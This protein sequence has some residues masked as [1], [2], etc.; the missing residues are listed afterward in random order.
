MKSCL[1]SPPS[2]GARAS[3]SLT[4]APS[5]TG[6]VIIFYFFFLFYAFLTSFFHSLFSRV[7]QDLP[8]CWSRLPPH[9]LCGILREVGPHPH[10]QHYCVRNLLSLLLFSFFFLSFFS[11]FLSLSFDSLSL[12]SSFFF[13]L[14]LCPG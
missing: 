2:S 7:S 4:S 12:Q 9:G 14:F 10:Q 3:A 11:S 5:L 1:R 13:F 6:R 8:G